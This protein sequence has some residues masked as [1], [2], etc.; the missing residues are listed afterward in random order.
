VV[1][2]AQCIGRDE[3]D[4]D[5]VV[6]RVITVRDPDKGGDCHFAWQVLGILQVADMCRKP[7]VLHDRGIVKTLYFSELPVR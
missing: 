2:V 3:R 1:I 5:N 4:A 6:V 7:L